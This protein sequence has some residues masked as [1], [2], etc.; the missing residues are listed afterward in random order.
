MKLKKVDDDDRTG[1]GP[2]IIEY[3]RA[4][5]L[6]VAEIDYLTSLAERGVLSDWSADSISYALAR[7]QPQQFSAD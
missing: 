2:A 1:V 6:S 4:K 5:G 3:L 7:R